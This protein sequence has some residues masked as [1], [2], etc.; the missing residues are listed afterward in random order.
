VSNESDV[1]DGGN[2][3]LMTYTLKVSDGNPP[4]NK[5]RNGKDIQLIDSPKEPDQ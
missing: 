5:S 1:K 3:F 2:E 4:Q